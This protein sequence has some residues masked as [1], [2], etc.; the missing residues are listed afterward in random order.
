M[1]EDNKVGKVVTASVKLAGKTLYTIA[2]IAG[3]I[4]NGRRV[5]DVG[6]DIE[7]HVPDDD[8]EVES[9]N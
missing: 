7:C 1:S 5:V 6:D 8:V 4:V 2:G 9:E 3:S